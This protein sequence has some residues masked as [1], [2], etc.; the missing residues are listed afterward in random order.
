MKKN[1]SS[2]AA[3]TRLHSTILLA[4]L[5]FTIITL[6]LAGTERL[7]VAGE[8]FSR[9]LQVLAIVL[10]SASIFIGFSLF[11]KTVLRI[12]SQSSPG[13]QKM[14]QYRSACMRWWTL[15]V[16]PGFFAA[17]CYVLTNNFSFVILSC[18]HIVILF[19]FRPRKDNIVLLLSLK[20]NDI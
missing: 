6:F 9:I 3:F 11:K 14:A 12:R 8:D 7:S 19:L 1:N 2:F 10:S 5:V 17:L 16:A 4:Q 13:V 20:P 18:M 15:L